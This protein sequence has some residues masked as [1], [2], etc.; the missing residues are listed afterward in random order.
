[1]QDK[2]A[3]QNYH[4]NVK[5]LRERLTDTFE[6]ASEN[7]TKTITKGSINSNKAIDFK[8]KSSRTNQ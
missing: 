4:Q 7:L 3:E 6:N 2:L 8:L 5:T 1:M